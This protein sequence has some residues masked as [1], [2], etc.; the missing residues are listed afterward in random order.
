MMVVSLYQPPIPTSQPRLTLGPI[1]TRTP[2]SSS[3][4]LPCLWLSSGR[5][6]GRQT[7]PG[8]RKLTT[9]KS[10]LSCRRLPDGMFN[11]SGFCFFNCKPGAIM[12]A[13]PTS[14]TGLP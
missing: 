14:L 3:R 5:A 4:L 13:P 1:L 8:A 6:G 9:K 10:D 2:E 12:P 7:G 11:F